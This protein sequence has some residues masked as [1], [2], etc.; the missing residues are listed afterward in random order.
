MHVSH[1][2][3]LRGQTALRATRW[4]RRV[5][6][7]ITW[8]HV[9]EDEQRLALTRATCLASR[10]DFEDFERNGLLEEDEILDVV[11]GRGAKRSPCSRVTVRQSSRLGS[12]GL[13]RLHS[14]I[15]VLSPAALVCDLAGE[16]TFAEQLT[17]IEELTGSWSLPERNV[18]EE[19][20]D[21]LDFIGK[22]SGYYDCEPAT[23]LEEIRKYHSDSKWVAG[24]EAARQAISVATGSSR[25]PMEAIMY[26]MFALPHPLGGF[27]CGP[28][29]PNY[30][31]VLTGKASMLSGLPYVIADAYPPRF[32]AII[33]YN[34]SYHDE[35]TIRRRDEA[36]ALG[37]MSMNVDVYRL[38]DLQLKDAAALESVARTLY[39]RKQIQFSPRARAYASKCPEL[40]RELRQAVG[41]GN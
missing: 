4:E 21:G 40:L 22:A 27:N 36:R 24:R 20:D 19:D 17:L 41:L 5:H 13:M 39:R 38:N 16:L 35:S 10:I 2:I 8:A 14:S 37:L 29:K 3:I 32:K 1:T 7:T 25:S 31:I 15:Y 34:G 26:C 9:D 6:S 28:L 33:E 30:K 23:S 11:V 18:A 12:G